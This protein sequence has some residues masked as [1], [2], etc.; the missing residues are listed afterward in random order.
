MTLTA[1]SMLGGCKLIDKLTKFDIDYTSSFTIPSTIIPIS[2][3]NLFTPDITTNTT[4]TFSNNNTRADL[5]ESVTLK[6]L[7]LTITSP[8]GKEFDFLKSAIVY[9]SAD[10]LP[11][12][13]VARIDDIDD[14]TTGGSIDMQPSGRE[15]KEYLKKDKITLRVSTTTD[16][17]VTESVNVRVDATFYVDAKILG[18]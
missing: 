2:V 3:L 5:V 4:Q 16:Q 1:V 18:V 12:V 13:E 8:A 11:E 14:A 17:V 9:I 7:K 10:G 6:K 15:L